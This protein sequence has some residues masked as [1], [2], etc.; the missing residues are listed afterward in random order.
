MDPG[1]RDVKESVLTEATRLFAAQGFEGTSVQA[2]ADAV[3]IR[4]PS[5]LYHYPSK[6]ALRRAVLDEVLSHWKDLVPRVLAES[7]SGIRR[8]EAALK[9]VVDFFSADPDRARLV[10]RELL[11]RPEEMEGLLREHLHP[12]MNLVTDYIRLG[13]QT[14][15]V[16]ADLDPEAWLVQLVTAVVATVAVGQPIT[17][18]L[19]PSTQPPLDRQVRELV[20]VGRT[21]LF[22]RTGP[23]ASHG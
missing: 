14:G 8:F 15:Q 7:S 19:P 17:A 22:S 16:H 5:L 21:S 12:W 13:Q 11:D 2:I 20:R 18:L 4:K 23:G 10:M 3:G 6:D 1:P 9:A